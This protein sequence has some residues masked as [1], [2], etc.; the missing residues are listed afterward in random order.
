MVRDLHKQLKLKQLLLD[1]FV[2]P[3]EVVKIEARAIWDD[4]MEGW[5]LRGIE[6][7][8]N[9]LRV[10]RPASSLAPAL[11]DRKLPGAP[12]CGD[13]MEDNLLNLDL[14]KPERTT[15]TY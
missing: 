1:E 3:T 15:E 10:R 5:L 9:R 7:C 13:L 6:V 2:P 12:A 14:E 4:E 8:G 11:S